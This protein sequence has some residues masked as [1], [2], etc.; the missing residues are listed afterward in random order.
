[1][2]ERINRRARTTPFVPGETIVVYTGRAGGDAVTTREDALPP[3]TAPHPED[4]PALPGT[5]PSMS[6]D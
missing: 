6:A 5:E 1:M 2:L 4:L 3:V